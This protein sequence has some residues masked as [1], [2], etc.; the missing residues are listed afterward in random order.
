ME[1]RQL[2]YFEAVADELHFGRAAQRL[3]MSQPPLSAQIARLEKQLGVSLFDRTNRQ[4]RLTPAG[5]HLQHRLR[6]ILGDLD[7]TV[8]EL[9]EYARG[10]A[11]LVSVGFVSSAN[12]ILLPQVTSLFSRRSE[13]RRVGKE[14]RSRSRGGA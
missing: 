8:Q 4:V 5:M 11:G 9:R 13:E 6:S 2:R 7:N 12:Y 14:G 3:H 10:A 1:L